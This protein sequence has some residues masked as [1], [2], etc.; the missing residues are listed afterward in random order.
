MTQ[1][2]VLCIILLELYVSAMVIIFYVFPRKGKD[3]EKGED[4]PK[5]TSKW[6][7]LRNQPEGKINATVL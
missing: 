2:R 5:G 3:I 6:A 4:G 7:A 1:E